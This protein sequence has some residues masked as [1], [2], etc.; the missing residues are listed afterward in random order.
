MTRADEGA[1]LC[2]HQQGLK[3]WVLKNA[4]RVRQFVPVTGKLG[5]YNVSL[6]PEGLGIGM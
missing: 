1:A 6:T 5:V 3:A 4:R 2:E